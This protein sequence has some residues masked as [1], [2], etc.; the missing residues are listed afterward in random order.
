MNIKPP[1]FCNKSIYCCCCCW[2]QTHIDQ[3]NNNFEVKLQYLYPLRL[4]GFH[5]IRLS[6]GAFFCQKSYL[7]TPC[8]LIAISIYSTS[9]E[10]GN[11]SW[12]SDGKREVN[13]LRYLAL[14]LGRV[15]CRAFTTFV[16]CNFLCSS[17]NK[18]KTV[19]LDTIF[20]QNW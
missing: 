17:H 1:L 8:V 4:N 11:K 7:F 2:G 18:K 3:C 20:V 15:L 12:K 16:Q 6:C 5:F 14:K 19:L 9:K 13:V 10:C